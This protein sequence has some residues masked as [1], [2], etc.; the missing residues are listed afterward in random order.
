MHCKPHQ[1]KTPLPADEALECETCDRIMDRS[2][3][4]AHQRTAI[5]R[6]IW[7]TRGEAEVKA[8]TRFF[9]LGRGVKIHSGGG[10]FMVDYPGAGSEIEYEDCVGF[11]E[12]RA[13]DVDRDKPDGRLATAAF[14]SDWLLLMPKPFI[15][16]MLYASA[17]EM[18]LLA[19]E[20]GPRET[21]GAEVVKLVK[22]PGP[23]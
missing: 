14:L 13:F 11:A 17:D 6:R 15:A 20:F 21:E 10:Y 8:F 1:W 5:I 16:S 23:A 7:N 12:L 4:T 19:R 18:L 3:A 22:D 9:V 2:E